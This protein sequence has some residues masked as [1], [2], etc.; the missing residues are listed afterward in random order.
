MAG[1]G[2]LRHGLVVVALAASGCKGRKDASRTAKTTASPSQG[3]AGMRGSAAPQTPFPV[4]ALAPGARF[5][6]GADGPRHAEDI[7][8]VAFSPDG[9]RLA[10]IDDRGGIFVWDAATGAPIEHRDSGDIT[11]LPVIGFAGDDLVVRGP[12]DMQKRQQMSHEGTWTFDDPGSEITEVSTG[13]R[14]VLPELAAHRMLELSVAGGTVAAVVDERAVIAGRLGEPLTRIAGPEHRTAH[15]LVAPDGRSVALIGDGAAIAIRSFPGTA[16]R[17]ITIP[18]LD[19]SDVRF[20]AAAWSPDGST[21]ALAIDGTTLGLV[22]VKRGSY[23]ELAHDTFGNDITFLAYSPDGTRIAGGTK[24]ARVRLW[25]AATGT[26]VHRHTGHIGTI[27]DVD[28]TD[29]GTTIVSASD[30]R[31]LS[32][33]PD[34]SAAERAFGD[35][36]HWVT[37]VAVSP[38]GSTLA[39][40]SDYG[41]VNVRS[42]ATG[43]RI[44][45]VQLRGSSCEG[46]AVRKKRVIASNGEWAQRFD[47]PGGSTYAFKLAAGRQWGSS[48]L[49]VSHDGKLLA[50][51][52]DDGFIAVHD[53]ESGAKKWRIEVP[54]EPDRDGEHVDVD[55]LAFDAAGTQLATITGDLKLSIR[56]AK[57]G[58]L[59]RSHAVPAGCATDLVF[60][61]ERI[62]VACE[63]RVH[64]FDRAGAEVATFEHRDGA[65]YSIAATATRLVIGGGDGSVTVWDLP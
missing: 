41:D 63:G 10:S 32:W 19:S 13:R 12:T 53:V 54:K 14:V 29:D 8:M 9:R 34:T 2:V 37:H 22:D 49:A 39:S 45:R 56:D 35:H 48:E 58:R 62:A 42:V 26:L 59:L 7:S 43:E 33:Q 20:T 1:A 31:M 11:S 18:D 36:E 25:D 65:A 51:G 6:L 5:V 27:W 46:L 57:T 64:V 44:A 21:L 28:T 61:G 60:A 23:R 38:D 17:A 55:A 16:Q 24:Y 3:D 4:L 15:A 40:C 47:V 50:S 52:G 30:E